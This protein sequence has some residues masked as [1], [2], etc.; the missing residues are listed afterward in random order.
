MLGDSERL[1]VL[2]DGRLLIRL[3]PATGRKRWSSLLGIEDLSQRPDAMANDENYFYCVNI[4][5]IFGSLNQSIRAVSL[6]D[7]SRAWSRPRTGPEDLLW[8]IALTDRCVIAYPSANRAAKNSGTENMPVIARRRENGDLVQRFVF[9]TAIANVAF[10]A[11]SRGA[12]LATSDGIWGLG[13]KNAGQ[14]PLSDRP[15]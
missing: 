10:K 15:R 12:M 1:L 13:V 5:N 8:S 11:D 4:E 6:K 14:P 7:G 2:H 9:Q 3:D